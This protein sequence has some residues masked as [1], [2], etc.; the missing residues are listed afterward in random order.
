MTELD[1]ARRSADVRISVTK[2]WHSSRPKVF[3]NGREYAVCM[4]LRDAE[5]IAKELAS[6]QGLA[7]QPSADPPFD[8]PLPPWERGRLLR[9][10]VPL[11]TYAR[12]YGPR[13]P[14][15]ATGKP[16]APPENPSNL[17]EGWSPFWRRL[18]GRS[19]P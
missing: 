7:R 8:E 11:V 10:A 4:R 9:V 15:P 17:T 19:R 16:P 14:S 5:R 3:V 1:A 2:A 12:N 6:S 18:L 13:L